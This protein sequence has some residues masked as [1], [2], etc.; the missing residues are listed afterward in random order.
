[1]ES[2]LSCFMGITLTSADGPCQTITRW[3]H[4]GRYSF[5]FVF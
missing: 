2:V 4:K 5:L 1:M 3:D